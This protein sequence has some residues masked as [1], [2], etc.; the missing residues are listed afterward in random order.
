MLADV[1]IFLRSYPAHRARTRNAVVL[2][3]RK[4]LLLCPRPLRL[5]ITALALLGLAACSADRSPESVYAVAE[6]GNPTPAEPCTDY[7]PERRAFFG[8]LHVHTSLSSDAY[9][10]GVT[11]T[12]EDAYRYA[13]GGDM[14]LTGG[15][16]TRLDRPLDFAAVTDHAEFLGEMTLCTN[17]DSGV[18]NAR[19]C[20]A[21]REGTGREPTLV[22]RIM[23][24][25]RLR[26]KETCG[27]DGE[28][29]GLATADS[30]QQTVETAERWNDRSADCQ[31][32]TFAAYE[33]SSFRLGSNLHRNVVFKSSAVPQRPVS[34]LEAI[35]E[36]D[37]WRILKEHCIDGS[38]NCDVLAIPHNSNI[39]NGRMFAVDYPGADSKAE[40]QARARL[41]STLEPIVEIM[42]HKGDSECRNDLPGVLADTDELCEFEQ[43][44]DFAMARGREGYQAEACYAGPF[45]DAL[46]HLGPDCLSPLS[47]VR[48][49]LVEGLA[50]K[51]LLGINP[52]KLGIIA[53]TD[54]HNGLAGGVNERDFPGHLGTG[55]ATPQQR[56]QYSQE[57][58]GNTSNNPGGLVGVWAEQNRREDLFDA[59]KRREVFGTSGPRIQPRLFAGWSLP[60][61]L[62]EQADNIKVA[63]QQAVPMGGD[64]PVHTDD[65]APQFFAAA[66]ADPTST[67][68]QQLQIVKG[69]IDQNGEQRTRV[70]TVAGD[71]NNGA[72]VDPAT[73]APQG[74]GSPQLCTVWQDNDFD[75]N[76]NALYYLRVVENPSC[77]YSAWQCL[78]LEGEDRPAHCDN[79]PV[80]PIIQ[81]RAWSSPIWYGGRG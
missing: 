66:M 55:D 4:L 57:I 59:M 38:D 6:F 62:C 13:F 1:A 10:F 5:P 23:A 18:Y 15:R 32:T 24:P 3:R 41:R 39:S 11:E 72:T 14:A 43:F 80:S 36:W 27:T 2:S 47:Y 31:R 75:P 44:E 29:C 12:P 51:E 79:P 50:Q 73:C 76:T 8:D 68:L 71:A 26:D 17:P 64:L 45:A 58:A 25:F 40:Q 61:N 78:S 48:N 33:Y 60:E 19:F 21:I 37:L 34:Y 16:S 9:S 53:S 28:R 77:R 81:E 20:S 7:S 35:R 63:Y 65:T 22:A 74:T 30:W 49:A 67:A 70:F 46:P 42:Q 56:V 54:T 52:Y 69:W